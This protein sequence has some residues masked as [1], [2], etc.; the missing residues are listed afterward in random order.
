MRTKRKS[1][2]WISVLLFVSMVWFLLLPAGPAL[3]QRHE[4]DITSRSQ[5]EEG[6]CWQSIGPDIPDDCG[7]WQVVASPNFAQDQTLFVVT[8]RPNASDTIPRVFAS[9]DGGSSW[10]PILNQFVTAM[11]VSPDFAQD[12]TLIAAYASRV[13]ISHDRGQTWEGTVDIPWRGGASALAFSPSF[14]QDKTVFLAGSKGLL[15]STDGGYHWQTHAGAPL[16]IK[17][18]G[19]SPDFTRDNTLFAGVTGSYEKNGLYRST[20]RGKTWE[21]VAALKGI[22]VTDVAFSPN[23]LQD[24]I[25]YAVGGGH[26]FKSTDGGKTWEKI[27]ITGSNGYCLAI[28]PRFATD[29]TVFV[30]TEGMGVKDYDGVVKCKDGLQ[31]RLV[32]GLIGK[33]VR[34]LAA[35]DTGT[36]IKLYAAVTSRDYRHGKVY[37]LSLPSEGGAPPVPVTK[38]GLVQR[39]IEY[40]FW[41][42]VAAEN[43]RY[44]LLKDPAHPEE[45][46]KLP[47]L[48]GKKARV[49]GYLDTGPGFPDPVQGHVRVI[50]VEP[51]PEP[52]AGQVI[53]NDPSF[54]TLTAVPNPDH[55]LWWA[56]DYVLEVKAMDPTEPVEFSYLVTDSDGTPANPTV[57]VENR[58]N[59]FIAGWDPGKQYYFHTEVGGWGKPEFTAN[60]QYF[61]LPHYRTCL[62]VLGRHDKVYVVFLRENDGQLSYKVLQGGP[63]SGLDVPG[64]GRVNWQGERFEVRSYGG[65]VEEGLW[66]N[67]RYQHDEVAG[68]AQ[69]EF[70]ENPKYYYLDHYAGRSSLGMFMLMI[71]RNDKVGLI[72][73][74][75]SEGQLTAVVVTGSHD[76]VTPEAVAD[77]CEVQGLGGP[78]VEVRATGSDPVEVSH[79]AFDNTCWQ[80]E[81]NGRAKPEFAPNPQTFALKH[82][83]PG[84]LM[85][86]RYGKVGIFF[87][88]EN[89]GQL[90]VLPVPPEQQ[91]VAVFRIGQYYYEVGGQRSPT[92]VAPYIKDGRSFVP[93]R[94]LANALGVSNQ[95]IT[96]DPTTQEVTLRKGDIILYLTVGSRV[97]KKQVDAILPVETVQMDVAPEIVNG[98]LCLP[99]RWVAEGFGYRVRWDPAAQAVLLLLL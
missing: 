72:I 31:E 57:G 92:D 14:A 26:L 35:V 50:K 19:V 84:F 11:G 75:E 55:H 96:W 95:D 82:Y 36:G 1:L 59:N 17:C 29:K 69:P 65:P 9:Y 10:H 30:G 98:R 90:G 89:D 28:S 37:A 81:V 24:R 23:Y 64:L 2:R 12:G 20:D 77:L 97:M 53:I 78:Q 6:S 71:A 34:D 58:E 87:Y 44:A 73:G 80:W 41:L 60:P 38:E 13:Y 51:L 21:Q 15:V 88:N 32:C 86:S 3:A 83:T 93:V 47:K 33:T 61:P 99:G 40:P 54:V 4:W 43:A 91:P 68:W 66:V 22:S 7:V 62:L 85:V 74:N 48:L 67:G 27:S 45:Y 5:G 76:W 79:F 70:K 25:V 52:V 42:E 39:G 49:T 46:D 16:N 8:Y 18:L 94:Y 56:T 63:F